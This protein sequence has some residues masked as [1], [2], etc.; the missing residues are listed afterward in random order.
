MVVVNGAVVKRGGAV[1]NTGVATSDPAVGAGVPV[2]ARYGGSVGASGFGA[3]ALPTHLVGVGF[4]L[5]VGALD[6]AG[7]IAM[8]VRCPGAVIYGGAAIATDGAAGSGGGTVAR[9]GHGLMH[10]SGLSCGAG[11]QAIHPP[12]GCRAVALGID[13]AGFTVFAGEGDF[14]RLSDPGEGEGGG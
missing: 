7:V 6:G 9:R 10:G 12:T 1:A 13:G 4:P 14:S 8:T 2:G 11:V 3:A 5:P